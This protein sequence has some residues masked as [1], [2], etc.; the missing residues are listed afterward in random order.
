MITFKIGDCLPILKEM[1]D[2]SVGMVL[3]DP[4]YGQGIGY[5]RSILGL[6]YVE[7]DDNLD[8]VPAVAEELY[9]VLKPD[10]WCVV[11]GQWRTYVDFYW[12]FKTVGFDI[13]TV[14]IWDKGTHGLGAGLAEAYE[15]IYVFR[16]GNARENSFRGNMFRFPM[17]DGRPSHPNQKPIPLF[18]ELIKLCSQPGD[19]VL[20]PF[21]GSGTTLAACKRT[22]RD[23]FGIEL[24]EEYEQTIKETILADVRGLEHWGV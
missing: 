15:Q 16:K 21:L 23:G 19:L 10:S 6:R 17:I 9:R 12:A 2:G 20:D 11:F 7:N 5:G 14:A 18:E 1:A 22:G 3:T 4:P 13:K 8:W 24:C